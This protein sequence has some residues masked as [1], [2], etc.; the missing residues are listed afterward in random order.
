MTI[1]EAIKELK[2]LLHDKGMTQE[3]KAL[4]LAIRILENLNEERIRKVIHNVG[5]IVFDKDEIE[6]SQAIIQDLTKGE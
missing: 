1:K 3:Q 5:T 4:N 2:N 6:A